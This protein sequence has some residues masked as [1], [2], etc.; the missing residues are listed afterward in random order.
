M[1]EKEKTQKK[2]HEELL[3]FADLQQS[4]LPGDA[5][6][7]YNKTSFILES[8]TRAQKLCQC[9]LWTPV[10]DGRKFCF[11]TKQEDTDMFI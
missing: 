10:H 3:L 9:E 5:S 11:A 1:I 4:C 8:T 2:E 6:H 7:A